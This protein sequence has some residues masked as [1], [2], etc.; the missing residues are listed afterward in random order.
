ME[1]GSR[2]HPKSNVTLFGGGKESVYNQFPCG[3]ASVKNQAC[4]G[5]RHSA[6][7]S[8]SAPGGPRASLPAA[9][10]PSWPGRLPL[11]V[12]AAQK[13]V[14]SAWGLRVLWDPGFGQPLGDGES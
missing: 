14:L 10:L 7:G 11:H 5:Q 2:S 6:A 3:S 13:W 4:R 1:F 12:A 8:H 9:R